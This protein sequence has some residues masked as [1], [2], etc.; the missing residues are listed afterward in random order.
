MPFPQLAQLFG[1]DPA[2]H[3]LLDTAQ[4]EKHKANTWVQRTWEENAHFVSGH[5]EALIAKELDGPTPTAGTLES[6]G[7]VEVMYPKLHTLEAPDNLLGRMRS[8]T[9]RIT[10]RSIWTDLVSL[11]LDTLRRDRIIDWSQDSD[12]RRWQD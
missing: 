11:L 8:E 3:Q 6:I 2:V 7:L 4:G 1:Q 5:T 9:V 10:L 12:A